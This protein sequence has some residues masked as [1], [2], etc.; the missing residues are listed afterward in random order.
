MSSY[1]DA[2]KKILRRTYEFR[3]CPQCHSKHISTSDNYYWICSNC[4]FEWNGDEF[5]YDYR[6]RDYVARDCGDDDDDCGDDDCYDDD[7][8][9]GDDDCGD[10]DD[11]CGDDDCY[12]DDD[13][14]GD[15][16][17]YD[18]DDDCGDDDCG[19]DD[20]DC[21]DDDC[22]DDDDDCYYW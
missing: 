17:C 5:Y 3:W 15:D 10:D 14:C 21:G 22:G 18:D 9:C 12:D 7:D 13:D 6:Q 1:N 4:G 16:D 2:I 11:D 20:D 8:D 19:D